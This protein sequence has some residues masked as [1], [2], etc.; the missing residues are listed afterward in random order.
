MG[1]L[2]AFVLLFVLI[3]YYNQPGYTGSITNYGVEMPKQYTLHG[4]D[5]SRY[6]QN[7]N[8]NRVQKMRSKGIQLQFVFIK[9][10]EST[11]IVDVN[12]HYNWQHAQEVNLTRGAYHYFTA[13]DDVQ[14]QAKLFCNTV[15]LHSGDLPPVVDVEKLFNNTP[16][17][18]RKKLKDFLI[19]LENHYHCKPII[20]TF[21]SFYTDHLGDAFNEYPLWVA[22]Y[23]KPNSP[24][25]RRPW[26]FWQ[27]ADRGRVDG[28][29]SKVDLNVFNGSKA[30]FNKIIIP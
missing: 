19:I 15:N 22:H 29:R 4:I 28:I 20:Y 7:I 30:D 25:T 23:F 5:V 1:V 2:L 27:H 3:Y 16:E 10:T 11:G 24:R 26:Q 6:Q 8:W 13:N 9:A 17:A 21:S 18:L 12:F 14:S